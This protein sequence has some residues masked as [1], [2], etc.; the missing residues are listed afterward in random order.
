MPLKASDLLDISPGV[1]ASALAAEGERGLGAVLLQ[2]SPYDGTTRL[3][4]Q[5]RK[6]PQALLRWVERIER[7]LSQRLRQSSQRMTRTLE[8]FSILN[9]QLP[10]GLLEA[11]SRSSGE[12]SGDSDQKAPHILS[13]KLNPAGKEKRSSRE[14]VQITAIYLR[15]GELEYATPTVM[16]WRNQLRLQGQKLHRLNQ[17]YQKQQHNQNIVR[18]QSL[19]H[20]GWKPEGGLEE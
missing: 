16:A 11:A 20:N 2:P 3:S 12:Y 13:L 10:E 18:A 15:L 19:W 14:P 1:L 9:N 17:A 6:E 5:A 7:G 4:D 8:T